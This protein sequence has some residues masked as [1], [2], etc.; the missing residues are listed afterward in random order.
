MINFINNLFKIH[1]K[2]YEV[3]RQL[4]YTM[5]EALQEA[6]L[7]EIIDTNWDTAFGHDHQFH[8]IQSAARFREVVPVVE[9]HEL[10]PYIERV[11]AGEDG[12]LTE[13]KVKWLAKTAG[14]TSGQSKYIPVTK[15]SIQSCHQKGSWFTLASMHAH[16]EDLQIFA[17][18][19]LLIGGG[20][21]GPHGAAGLPVGDI[22]AI[23]IQAIPLIIRPFYI[24]D[25]KTATLPDYEK[26]V[27]IIAEIAANEDSITMLG[28]VPTW[29]L[30]LYRRI[31]EITGAEHLLE[32]WPNLQAYIHGGVSFEPYRSHFEQLIPSSQMLY[33]EVYNASEGYFAIQDDPEKE[34]L[35][36]LLS[37]GIYYE[38]I[39]LED[40]RNG[41]RQAIPLES[42]DINKTYAIVIS[43][44]TGLY[45]YL[46][47]DLV[48]FTATHP[49][50]IKVAGRVQEYINAF[51]EDLLI[52]QAE[53]ALVDSCR[54]LG[55]EI[56]DYT[57]APYYSNVKEKGRH[58]WF[59]EFADS[60]ED[61]KLFAERL[62]YRLQQENSNYAQKR[63]ND[64]AVTQLEIVPLPEG[65][66]QQWLREKGKVGGQSKAPKL[67]ND[68]RFA[69]E[70]LAK[71][72]TTRTA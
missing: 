49:Y 19:N 37:N 10:L 6:T 35:L 24:P 25:I 3:E 7:H 14:T 17:K 60:I 69:E 57:I 63:S 1:L 36:L 4:H 68:R 8:S 50:R 71:L 12:V 56:R 43:S 40:I 9:Y 54:E 51:G 44:N 34:D 16:R 72:A 46:L 22:S 55:V 27:K 18:R 67:S 5:P 29:N 65:F 31:L 45:R 61:I 13:A 30:A 52:G 66:F 33:H 2:K 59:I 38:F 32:I 41:T 47:G 48:H 15:E 23:L 39:A 53:K 62:D 70:I 21:Y 28:G 42:V 58:Q 64:F 26:K 20:A 11:I